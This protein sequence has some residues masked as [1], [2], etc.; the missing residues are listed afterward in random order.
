M[1]QKEI[2]DNLTRELADRGQII[3]GG[4]KALE[5][6]SLQGVSDVQ[7][8]EMRKAYFLGAQHLWASMMGILDPAPGV[9]PTE[10]DMERFTK[11]DAELEKFVEEM[12]GTVK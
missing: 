2:A 7:R 9:E 12:K 5:I 3:E 8:S 10:L 6:L 4:W 11:I 1:T